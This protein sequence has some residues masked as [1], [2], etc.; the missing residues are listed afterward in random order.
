VKDD[1]IICWD[2]D[3]LPTSLY[4]IVD[5]LDIEK[6]NMCIDSSLL[7]GR[8]PFNHKFRY[9]TGLMGIPKEYLDF[10]ADVYKNTTEPVYPSYE[11]HYFNDA[12]F[13]DDIK[14]N[15]LNN[16]LNVL[17]RYKK[18]NKILNV[19]Y[20]Y[21]KLFDRFSHVKKHN[22]TYKVIERTNTEFCD[23]LEFYDSDKHPSSVHTYSFEYH[24]IFSPIRNKVGGILEVSRGIT[25][26]DS[27]RAS[28]SSR[29]MRDYFPYAQVFQIDVKND[30]T[31]H[32]DRLNCFHCDFSEYRSSKFTID[33]KLKHYGDNI[34][35][36]IIVDDDNDDSVER[37]EIIFKSLY[38]RLA[39][40]GL[41][42]IEDIRWT[43]LNSVL[44][45]ESDQ[46]K[47]VKKYV[48]YEHT[49]MFVAF[50]RVY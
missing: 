8:N 16:N 13:D 35:F 22:D 36:D 10:F 41:Y 18:N 49:D 38:D 2:L 20:S 19:H 43:H 4:K 45:M 37:H 50:Q 46:F 25:S 33:E 14:V 44:K 42:I 1:F 17:D 32:E 12:L 5:Y 15:V 40:G 24:K 39:V 21:H 3:L 23:I 31:H 7:N 30:V 47:I 34:R 48:G 11:Q 27:Y 9:N 26:D 6:I 29:T 28:P